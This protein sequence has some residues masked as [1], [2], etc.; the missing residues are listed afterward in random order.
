MTEKIKDIL[1]GVIFPF[2][3]VGLVILFVSYGED[4]RRED[5]DDCS[6]EKISECKSLVKQFPELKEKYELYIRDDQFL[7]CEYD[8]FM[9]D[10][11]KLKNREILKLGEK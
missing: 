11:R 7:N 5:K 6:Q 1:C 9:D 10:L 4:L 3:I 8:L 2:F